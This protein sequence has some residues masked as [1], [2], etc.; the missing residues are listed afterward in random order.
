MPL[1]HL[2]FSEPVEPLLERIGKLPLPPYIEHAAQADDEAR[3]QTV[4]A[5]QPGAVAAPTAGLHFDAPMMARLRERGVGIAMLTL[6]V[7]SGTFLPVRTEDLALHR[8]HSERFEIPQ[9]TARRVEQARARGGRVI[10]VGTTSLRALEASGGTRRRAETDIF[11]TPGYRFQRGR[12]PDHQ[13][14]PAPLDPA[15]AGQR[16]RRG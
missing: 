8:M 7:G 10:A 12:Q 5:S 16:L 1:Y 11:I 4:Y 13:L 9:E 3:Y 14:P 15:D 2:S 6:H